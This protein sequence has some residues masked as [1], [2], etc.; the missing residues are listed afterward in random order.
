MYKSYHKSNSAIQSRSKNPLK[1]I[2]V[3][4]NQN[5]FEN[6]E[7]V[8]V[9]YDERCIDIEAKYIGKHPEYTDEHIVLIKAVEKMSNEPRNFIESYRFIKKI[10]Y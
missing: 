5:E 2:K 4:Q 10:S 7:S 3:I 1:R 9:G 6:G 8:L